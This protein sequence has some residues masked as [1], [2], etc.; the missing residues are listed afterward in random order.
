MFSLGQNQKDQGS[1]SGMISKAQ[2]EQQEKFL[3]MHLLHHY[4]NDFLSSLMCPPTEPHF[5]P[6]CF[7]FGPCVFVLFFYIH[8]QLFHLLS[9]FL[10]LPSCI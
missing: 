3:K 9:T 6:Y 2:K 8:L 1:E 7:L 4:I 5:V 10:M